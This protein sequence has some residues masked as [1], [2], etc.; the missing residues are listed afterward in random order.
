[1]GFKAKWKY[2][3]EAIWEKVTANTNSRGILA[4]KKGAPKK[5]RWGEGFGGMGKKKKTIQKN[6]KVQKRYG[7]D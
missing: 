7:R 6:A 3:K 4:E 1:L 2:S 5:D